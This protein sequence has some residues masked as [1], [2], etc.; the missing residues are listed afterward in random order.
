MPARNLTS[1]ELEAVIRR[2]VELQ[3]GPASRDEGVPDT[4][5]IRIGQELGLEPGAVRRAIAEVRSRPREERGLLGRSMGPG[6]VR[7][8]RVL[9]R[10]AA[11]TG[12]LIE[13][14]LRE[15]ELMV[16]QRRFPDRTRYLKDSSLAAGLTRLA[17]GFTRSGEPL[18]LKQLDVGV[19]ALDADRSLEA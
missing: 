18:N 5:V 13:Q 6:T 3:A 16:V 9:R 11:P 14:Y 4:E 2:A 15:S 19:A 1:Q 7:A 17:R 10:P 8:A 12:L